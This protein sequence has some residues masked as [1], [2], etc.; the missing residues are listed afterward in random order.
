MMRYFSVAT[1]FNDNHD[2]GR[3]ASFL[4]QLLDTAA[5]EDV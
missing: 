2:M 1:Q 3:F 5:I 4:R